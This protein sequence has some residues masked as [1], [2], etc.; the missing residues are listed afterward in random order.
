[1]SIQSVHLRRCPAHVP[2][3][4]ADERAI[5]IELAVVILRYLRAVPAAIILCGVSEQLLAALQWLLIIV[6]VKHQDK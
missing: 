3:V 5:F 2:R 1:M 6:T 4:F